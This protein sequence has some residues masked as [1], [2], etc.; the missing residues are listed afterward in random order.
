[1][2]RWMATCLLVAGVFLAAL[3]ASADMFQH[4]TG[5]ADIEQRFVERPLVVGKGWVELGLGFDWKHSGSQFL[6]NDSPTNVGFVPGTNFERFDNN[7]AFDQRRFT[8]GLR[9]G[10]TKGTDVYLRVPMVWNQLRNDNEVTIIDPAGDEQT[11]GTNIS[12][13]ALGDV[14]LGVLIQWLRRVDPNGRFNSSLGSHVN[15]KA[16]TGLESPGTYIASPGLISVMPT[17]TGTYNY[18]FDLEFKQQIAFLAVDVRAGYVWR[19][20]GIVQ[21]LVE[22]VEHQ[23]LLRLKPGDA[24]EWGLMLYFQPTRFLSVGIGT[25]MEYRFLAK[26]GPSARSI[27]QCKECDPIEGSNGLYMDGVAVISLT[28]SRHF[29]VDLRAQYT[30]GGREAFLFPLEDVSPTRGVTAGGNV[31]YRF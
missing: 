19:S 26:I 14:E 10:F 2:M 3:P 28:P 17:G 16:P 6:D 4:H 12:T 29:Q 25:D 22:D 27:A 5:Q 18:G 21:Y 11:I 24:V 1:M 7:A 31:M 13:F 9:W 15:I 23:F 20:S 30:F 8:L